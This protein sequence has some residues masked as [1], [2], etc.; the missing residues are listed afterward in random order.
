M[1]IIKEMTYGLDAGGE[2]YITLEVKESCYSHENHYEASP[3]NKGELPCDP[4]TP[5][6]VNAQRIRDYITEILM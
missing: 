6:M 3:Q 1:T 2:K 4:V 5:F